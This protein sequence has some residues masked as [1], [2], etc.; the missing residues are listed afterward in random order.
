MGFGLSAADI[1]GINEE[2]ASRNE[3]TT[4]SKEENPSF[5]PDGSDDPT[6]GKWSEIA[7]IRDTEY[8]PPKKDPTSTTKHVF[9]IKLEI[10]G[11][12]EG[13]CDKPNGGRSFNQVIYIDEADRAD[14]TKAFGANIRIGLLNSVLA[15]A[16]LDLSSGVDDYSAFF[17][18]DKPLLGAKVITTWSTR[19]WSS[20]GQS[21]KSFD[22]TGFFPY[23]EATA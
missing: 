23:G 17:K 5:E 14:K 20:Q 21:G 3:L 1:A 7:I 10:Q 11:A 4:P 19:Q 15:A 6:L 2:L 9:Q 16:G 12:A 13:G 22:C 8:G 18:G